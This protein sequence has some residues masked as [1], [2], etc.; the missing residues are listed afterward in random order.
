MTYPDNVYIEPAVPKATA[1]PKYFADLTESSYRSLDMIGELSKLGL[2]G[3]PQRRNEYPARSES[4]R[5]RARGFALNDFGC[6]YGVFTCTS[7]ATAGR[8][9]AEA[10]RILF[11][12]G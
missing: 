6:C 11:E 10:R 3:T 7:F 5:R 8:P 9:D 4:K 12:Y 1:G 2:E